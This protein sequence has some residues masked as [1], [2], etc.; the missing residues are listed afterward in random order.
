MGLFIVLNRTISILSKKEEYIYFFKALPPV[1]IE[2]IKG[3]EHG[4]QIFIRGEYK[5]DYEISRKRAGTDTIPR[6]TNVEVQFI[7]CSFKL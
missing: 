7:F 2:H 4:F 1:Y 6:Q 5:K 3:I